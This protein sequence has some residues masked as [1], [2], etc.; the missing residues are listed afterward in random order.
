[1]TPDWWNLWGGGILWQPHHMSICLLGLGPT[2]P[3]NRLK[4]RVGSW[5]EGLL[6]SGGSRTEKALFLP[7]M[8]LQMAEIPVSLSSHNWSRTSSTDTPWMR[9]I[10]LKCKN[11]CYQTLRFPPQIS[12][13]RGKADHLHFGC[14]GHFS[15]GPSHTEPWKDTR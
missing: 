6:F 8:S 9:I 2:H 11:L 10:G 15:Q 4:A 14:L 7:Q 5:V 3:A 1:M 13:G 12:F